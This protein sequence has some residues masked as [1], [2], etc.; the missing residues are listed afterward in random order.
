[1][2]AKSGLERLSVSLF[3]SSFSCRLKLT[4]RGVGCGDVSGLRPSSR[5]RNALSSSERQRRNGDYYG[6]QLS[7]RVNFT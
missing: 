4:V 5:E 2:S 6:K 7:D 3:F 1:V